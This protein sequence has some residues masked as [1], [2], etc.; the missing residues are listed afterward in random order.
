MAT[1]ILRRLNSCL[2]AILRI[3]LPHTFALIEG[4]GQVGLLSGARSETAS[5]ALLLL[6]L[7]RVLLL[8]LCRL[9]LQAT[10]PRCGRCSWLAQTWIEAPCEGVL[11]AGSGTPG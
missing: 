8:G 5:K 7:C 11:A 3:E 4:S 10:C 6:I 1:D 2:W 9:E